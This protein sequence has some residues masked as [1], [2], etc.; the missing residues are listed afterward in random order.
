MLLVS[1][2]LLLCSLEDG[3]VKKHLQ[4]SWS[5]LAQDHEA[6]GG[7]KSHNSSRK[8]MLMQR[9]S[10]YPFCNLPNGSD[11]GKDQTAQADCAQRRTTRMP[12]CM[13]PHSIGWSIE[14][15]QSCMH[16]CMYVWMPLH[17]YFSNWSITVT[18]SRDHGSLTT[19]LDTGQ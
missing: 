19:L 16:T 2:L 11:H 12:A 3:A 4:G 15:M 10:S 1:C 18:L 14:F 8:Q 13:H 17:T 6:A 5:S 9:S 7:E